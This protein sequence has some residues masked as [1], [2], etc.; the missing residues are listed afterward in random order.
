MAERFDVVVVGGGN[1]GLCAAL[2]ARDAGA[3]V[4]VLE[5]APQQEAGGNSAFTSGA[6]RVAY[7]STADLVEL[8]DEVPDEQL[9]R[10]DFGN[11]PA[12][13]FFDDIARVTEHRSDPELAE[14]LVDRS[15]EALRWMRGKGVRFLPIYGRQSVEVDGRFVFWGNLVIEA[16]GGGPGLV[17]ALTRRALADGVEIRYCTRAVS[18]RT[19]DGRVNGIRVRHN[20]IES[21]LNAGAVVLAS[22]GFEANTEWRTRYLGPGW[23]TAKVRGTRFNTGDGIRMALDV[24][25]MSWG[26]WSGAH[27]V[28]WDFNAPPFGNLAVGDG[29][30]KY[31][32]PFSIM[33]N[34]RGER[35]ADEGAD[36]R[37][38]TYAKYGKLILSQPGQFAWQV[39]DAKTVPLLRD[40]YRISQVT[41]VTADSIEQLAERLDGVDA[42]RFLATVAAYNAAVDT[43]TDF[44]PAERDGKRTHGL[45]PD[46]TNWAQT[47]DTAPFHA[48]H[49]TCGITFTF[50]GLRVTTSA[51]V[52]DDDGEEI[53]GLYACGELVGGLFYFNYPG[54]SG[55]TSGAVF[56][57][58]AGASAAGA[59]T[60]GVGRSA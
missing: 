22:G 15:L 4:L 59:A 28:A 57:R 44:N 60:V 25:A 45:T 46:K 43:A 51:Q 40:E 2:S 12:S 18:L 42:Q 37:N 21:T 17:S 31:S 11:Y 19:D 55:L 13:T 6:M 36:F 3:S 58:I 52:V 30:Q 8:I 10:T 54:G 39:F 35:F 34:G 48:Y 32:Y 23:D 33:V 7:D 29:Y 1:A 49:V 24:G 27:A 5:R 56:G 26:H 41:R 14:I 20:G 53:V 50:G 16:S 38:Y 9:G 47:I